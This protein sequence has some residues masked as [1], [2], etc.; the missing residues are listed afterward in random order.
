MKKIINGKLYNTESAKKIASYQSNFSKNDF[1]YFEEDLYKKRSGEFF[2]FGKGNAASPYHERATGGGWDE[3]ERIIPLKYEEAKRWA[4][5]YLEA[6]EY[7]SIFGEP[8]E[9]NEKITL[10]IQVT[11]EVAEILKRKA[12]QKGCTQSNLVNTAIY[13]IDMKMTIYIE[14]EDGESTEYEI[15]LWEA[16]EHV[17]QT[18]SKHGKITKIVLD[19]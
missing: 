5:E 9:S 7:C 14:W 8:D 10:G 16:A 17:N 4:E 13:N 2:I 1:H 6:D 3:G 18:H 19:W 15:N 12:A 11:K